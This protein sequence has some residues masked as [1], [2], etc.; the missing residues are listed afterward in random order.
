MGWPGTEWTGSSCRWLA[1]NA[2]G[3]LDLNRPAVEA[4]EGLE[5]AVLPL[6]QSRSKK[7]PKR[8]VTMNPPST[9]FH[10]TLPPFFL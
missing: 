6:A 7:M 5:G 9:Q 4:R 2:R 10:K 3:W 8:K 1:L